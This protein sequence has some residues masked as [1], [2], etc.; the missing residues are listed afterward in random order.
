MI[1]LPFPII[2]TNNE[3]PAAHEGL[4]IDIGPPTVAQIADQVPMHGRLG[5]TR[6]RLRLVR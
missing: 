4:G 1:P 5:M 6:R 3:S 2:L